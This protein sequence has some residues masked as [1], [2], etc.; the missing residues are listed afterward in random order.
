MED[1]PPSMTNSATIVIKEPAKR[2]A[3]VKH[4][5]LVYLIAD[6]RLNWTSAPINNQKRA[7][8]NAGLDR[9]SVV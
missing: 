8:G 2:A 7:Y 4:N 1:Y 3:K 5:W 6:G 9:K